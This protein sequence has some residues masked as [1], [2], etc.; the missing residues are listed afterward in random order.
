V[1]IF[2]TTLFIIL[3]SACSTKTTSINP[4]PSQNEDYYQVLTTFKSSCSSSKVKNLYPKSC[5][6]IQTYKLDKNS[7]KSF[8]TNHFKII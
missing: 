6:D 3:F 1:K 5:K 2:I 4:K 7:A 8:F